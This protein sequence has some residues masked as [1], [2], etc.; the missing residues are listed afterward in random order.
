MQQPRS[1]KPGAG[2][3]ITRL[4]AT[5]GSMIAMEN[6]RLP[7]RGITRLKVIGPSSTMPNGCRSIDRMGMDVPASKLS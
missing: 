7:L 5:F 4:Q 6:G 2:G 3:L 1:P